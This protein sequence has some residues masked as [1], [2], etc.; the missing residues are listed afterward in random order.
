MK[1]RTAHKAAQ[2]NCHV[3]TVKHSSLVLSRDTMRYHA[4]V[5]V[6]V[7]AVAVAVVVVV[8]VG[9]VVHKRGMT[10]YLVYI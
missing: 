2:Q 10:T 6:V 3:L 1:V 8:V 7:V 5:V 4:E 9:V